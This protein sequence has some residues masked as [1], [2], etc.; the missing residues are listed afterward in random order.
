[1]KDVKRSAFKSSP[2]PW[3]LWKT[4]KTDVQA[5]IM[6][7]LEE[8]VGK[9]NWSFYQLCY[10][11]SD[12]WFKYPLPTHQFWTIFLKWFNTTSS[13]FTCT[14]VFNLLE[15]YVSTESRKWLFLNQNFGLG[16]NGDTHVNLDNDEIIV[17]SFI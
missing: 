5:F 14:P 9:F 10:S 1:M 16:R 15:G 11:S 6:V 8:P 3:K 17:S 4:V 2:T 7:H 13:F 12:Y